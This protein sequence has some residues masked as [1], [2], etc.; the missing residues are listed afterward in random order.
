MFRVAVIADPHFHDTAWQPQGSGLQKACRSYRDTANSTRVFNESAP[1]LKAALDK[2][3][4]HGVKLVIIPG[5]LTDDGQRHNIEASLNLLREYASRYGIRY[6]A[7]PGNHDFYALNGRQQRKEFVGNDGKRVIL[8]SASIQEDDDALYVPET[9]TMGTEAALQLMPDLGYM[10]HESDIYWE[11]PFGQKADYAGRYHLVSSADKS[12]SCA[13]LDASY[14]VEPVEGLWL[15]SLDVNICVPKNGAV[16]FNDPSAFIDPTNGGWPTLLSSRPYLL[17]WMQDVARRA[18]EKGKRLIA[19]SHYPALDPLAGTAAKE[20]TLFDKSGLARRDP[21][22]EVA[23][24]FAATGVGIHLSGHL[25]VND[26]AFFHDGE[27]GFYNI[28]VPSTVGYAPSMKILE[29][30]G[31]KL[32]MQTLSL[33]DA[34]DFDV[35]FPAYQAEAAKAG[36]TIE[37]VLSSVDY[38]AFM[39]KHL[40]DLVEAR[41][42]P[43]EWPQ[44]MREMIAGAHFA[45]L[46]QLLWPQEVFEGDNLPLMVFCQDWYRLR[47]AA[48][49]A[50]SYIPHTRMTIY[51]AWMAKLPQ[52][53]DALLAQKFK[54]VLEI[55]QAYVQRIPTRHC[56]L[57]IAEI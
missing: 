16:D 42:F 38:G 23:K 26:T 20:R 30:G 52:V 24:A 14:L 50:L 4:A 36:E 37:Q 40:C 2:V 27:Q 10:P 46:A 9:A 15:L 25:H 5:D 6:F 51:Q 12:S 45:D 21:G 44:D 39:D 7:T 55:M 33:H 13:L 18:R 34:P 11:T 31:S 8:E 43:R 1:A 3:V 53:S 19:F 35:A 41:Y 47:K 56:E 22:I 49:L 48:D 57:D 29:I 17:V 32:E 54:T 28:A